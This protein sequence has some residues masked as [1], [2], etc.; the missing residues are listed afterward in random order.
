MPA[1]EAVISS[2]NFCGRMPERP[3]RMT[4]RFTPPCCWMVRAVCS[5]R[6]DLKKFSN[7]VGES[8]PDTTQASAKDARLP[9]RSIKPATKPLRA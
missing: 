3:S 8:L 9:T 6:P 5:M 4:D 2:M 7:T 1:A